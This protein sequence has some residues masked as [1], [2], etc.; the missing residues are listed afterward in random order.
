MI[1]VSCGKESKN[2]L[3]ND[4]YMIMLAAQITD[5]C[6]NAIAKHKYEPA[7]VKIKELIDGATA[8]RR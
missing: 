3:C 2:D 4:C 1:C 8:R 5:L 7:V 6:N